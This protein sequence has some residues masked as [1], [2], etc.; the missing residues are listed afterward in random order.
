MDHHVVTQQTYASR[1]TG[2]ALGNQTTGHFTHIRHLEDVL[3]VRIANE[4]LFDFRR[5]QATC[6]CFDVIY[7]IID[8]RV[9]TDLNTLL[10]RHVTCG[11]ICTDVKTK[12]RRTRRFGKADVRFSDRTNTRVKY[13]NTDF[14]VADFVHR[15]ADRFGRT[16][17]VSFY[18]NWQLSHGLVCFGICHQLLKRRCSTSGRT[19]VFRRLS[20]IFR[21]FTGL[22]FGFSHV[23]H[24]TSFGCAVKTQNLNRN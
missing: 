10:V 2:N 23:K 6:G 7:Q 15:L 9:I 24:V 5:K 17:N 11:S 16:L 21:D 14:F 22:R 4:V 20:T 19:F 18:N 13:T 12:D 1:T 8:D 3:N